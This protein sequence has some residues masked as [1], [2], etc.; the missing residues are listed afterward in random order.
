[1]GGGQES[2]SQVALLPPAVSNPWLFHNG[3]HFYSNKQGSSKL[4][5]SLCEFTCHNQQRKKFQF[6]GRTLCI[7]ST[8]FKSILLHNVEFLNNYCIYW[9]DFTFWEPGFGNFFLS[10]QPGHLIIRLLFG[11][12]SDSAKQLEYN[13]SWSTI[14]LV[15]VKSLSLKTMKTEETPSSFLY[16]I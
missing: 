5:S 15:D 3:P 9:L 7:L 2:F 1:M 12:V 4:D 6:L 16:K 14:G 10:D 8:P 13:M 11:F